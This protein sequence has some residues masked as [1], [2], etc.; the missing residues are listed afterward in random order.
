[1]C[2]FDLYKFNEKKARAEQ[3]RFAFFFL[4][5]DF[6]HIFSAV[7]RSVFSQYILVHDLF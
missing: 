3:L 1:M 4:F 6:Y 7:F 2:I 5:D